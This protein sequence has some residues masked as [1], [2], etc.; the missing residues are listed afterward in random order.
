[1]FTDRCAGSLTGC[2]ND[3]RAWIRRREPDVLRVLGAKMAGDRR[4]ASE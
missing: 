2:S 1:M 4:D 3:V